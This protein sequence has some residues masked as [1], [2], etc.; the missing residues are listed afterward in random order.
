VLVRA[1]EAEPEAFGGSESV[2]VEAA[3]LHS[4][5]DL[6]KVCEVSRAGVEHERAGD[7]EE[8]LRERRAL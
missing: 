8:R 6:Q 7:P 1:R 3:R 4:V 5:P 2:L